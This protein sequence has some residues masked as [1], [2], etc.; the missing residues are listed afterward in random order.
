MSYWSDVLE[1]TAVLVDLGY[2]KDPRLNNAFEYI[3]EKQDDQ[4]R[5]TMEKT[6]NGKMWVD[7]EEKGRPSKWVTLRAMRA[8]G[9]GEPNKISEAANNCDATQS[10]K[11]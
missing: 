1:T 6:L 10:L 9:F 11:G 7:V 5:W 8:L 2:G 3:L 4:G